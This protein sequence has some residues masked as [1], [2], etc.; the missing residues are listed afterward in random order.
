VR[1]HKKAILTGGE[2]CQEFLKKHSDIAAEPTVM[3]ILNRIDPHW[4]NGNCE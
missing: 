2:L 1:I 3:E 4:N